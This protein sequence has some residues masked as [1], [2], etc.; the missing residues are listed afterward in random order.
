M[1]DHVEVYPWTFFSSSQTAH[2]LQHCA[3]NSLYPQQAWYN[4]LEGTQ[5]NLLYTYNLLVFTDHFYLALFVI[6]TKMWI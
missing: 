4:I 2:S 6:T 5:H 3:H 1:H